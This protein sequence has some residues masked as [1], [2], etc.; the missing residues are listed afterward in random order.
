MT[1]TDHR[2]SVAV[3]RGEL[4]DEFRAHGGA[5]VKA[6]AQEM[7][8]AVSEYAEPLDGPFGALLMRAVNESVRYALD[9]AS[10]R[11]TSSAHYVQTYRQLGEVEFTEDRDLNFLQTAYRVGGRVAWRF[12]AAF[13]QSREV[14]ADVMC[15]CAH[16]V[17]VYVDEISQL[18]VEGYAAARANA[19]GTISRERRRLLDQI[20]ADPPLSPR[21]LADQAAVARWALPERVTMLA[22][23]PVDQPASGRAELDRLDG[24]D[25]KVLM[26]L[27]APEPCLLTTD[28]EDKLGWLARPL[29]GRR[30][31]V[32]PT[33]RLCDAAMSLSRAR[34]TLI[35]LRRGVIAD[36]PMARWTDHLLT[37]RLLS[38][39]F[40]LAE[41]SSRSLAPLGGLTVRQRV[42]LSETLLAW[43]QSRGGAPELAARLGIHPQTVR[44]RMRQLDALFGD[45][46]E[47]P[48]ERLTLEL[49]LRAEQ[50]A[51]ATGT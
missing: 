38:D 3:R 50:L 36:T 22:L 8:N 45:R 17:F 26:K 6:I 13:G 24:L 25:G 29:A 34:Q 15:A 41:L 32:G 23:E 28:P 18:S 39:R 21:E 48:D 16:A 5:M 33:V 7:R 20:L 10:G 42:R 30:V 43:L 4:V 37:I 35:M 46:L 14:S 12:L 27:D 40:L 19:A 1:V 51:G 44:Y 49:A 9:R 2:T 31:A 11:D 47:D